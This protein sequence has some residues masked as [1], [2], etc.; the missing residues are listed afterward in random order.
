VQEIAFRFLEHFVWITYAMGRMGSNHD[1][2]WDEEDGF[3]Y[4][5]GR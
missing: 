5:L 1:D 3:F 4:D 2:M